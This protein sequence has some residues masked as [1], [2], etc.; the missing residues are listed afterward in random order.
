MSTDEKLKPIKS[1][2]L[3]ALPDDDT[4]LYRVGI[5]LYGFAS[6]SSFMA[7]VTC[8]LDP[9]QNRTKL[10]EQMGGGLLKSFQRSAGKI[11]PSKPDVGS[12]S[13]A[14]ADLFKVLNAER[15]DIVHAYPITNNA[16]EQILHRRKNEQGKYFE[17]TNDFLNSFISRLHD[18]SLKLYE[19]R[20]ILR[21]DLGD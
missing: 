14:A 21:P 6:I 11:A 7:E 9:D 20:S 18:V 3:L 16:G 1:L 2:T 13:Q 19:I 4:Y 17:V 8:Y 10:E 5:A 12:I 15:S